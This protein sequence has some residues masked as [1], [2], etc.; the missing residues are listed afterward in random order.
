M[1]MVTVTVKFEIRPES[2]PQENID[3]Y[4][5]CIV[6]RVGFRPWVQYRIVSY[7]IGDLIA[8]HSRPIGIKM[9][10]FQARSSEF[11][12]KVGCAWA[13]VCTCI[14]VGVRS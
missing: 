11:K 14:G 13:W 10:S 2:P 3:I 9:R 4:C 12:R 7:R 6:F 5:N 8:L 1:V